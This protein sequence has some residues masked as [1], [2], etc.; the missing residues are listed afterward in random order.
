VRRGLGQR[1]GSGGPAAVGGAHGGCEACTHARVRFFHVA[2]TSLERS[3][4]VAERPPRVKTV[5]MVTAGKVAV[6]SVPSLAR[7]PVLGR[8]CARIQAHRRASE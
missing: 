4:R 6:G 2:R 3:R 8:T 7:A 5:V 1:G